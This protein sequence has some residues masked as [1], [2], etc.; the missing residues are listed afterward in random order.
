MTDTLP[1]TDLPTRAASGVPRVAPRLIRRLVLAVF[2]VGIAGMIITSINSN[3][4][5]AL[6]FGLVTA[7]AA[8]GLVLVTSVAPPGSLGPVRPTEF[9]QRLALDLEDRIAELVAAGADEDAVRRLVGR[10]VDLGRR[11]L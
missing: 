1:P 10:A 7:I 5:G 6:A 3:N 2:A 4:D 11:G 9:D 8:I